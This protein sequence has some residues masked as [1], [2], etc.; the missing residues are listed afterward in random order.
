MHLER[1]DAEDVRS[2]VKLATTLQQKWSLYVSLD[3]PLADIRL[4]YDGVPDVGYTRH[5]ADASSSVRQGWFEHP[6]PLPRPEGRELVRWA[7][8]S[9]ARYCT[10]L[11]FFLGIPQARCEQ[12]LL[13]EDDAACRSR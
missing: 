11:H 4:F 6:Q 1:S 13:V 12:G 2:H 7:G 8:L 5:D 9:S 3:H 10:L